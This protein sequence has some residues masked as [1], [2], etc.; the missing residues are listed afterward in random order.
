V[1]PSNSPA[2]FVRSF[3]CGAVAVCDA[4]IDELL[5]AARSAAVPGQRAALLYQ[6]AGQIDEQQLFLPLAAP[7]RWS[8]VSARVPGFSVNRY[9][10]HTLT[11]LALPTSS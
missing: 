5:A 10:R 3:R 8:L 6:A 1:A 9:A 7:V 2:W 4:A 11:D